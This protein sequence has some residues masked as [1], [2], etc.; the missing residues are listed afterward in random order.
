MASFTVFANPDSTSKKSIP[1]LLDIQSELLSTLDTRVVVPLYL[2]ST[3]Q[4]LPISRLTPVLSFQGK[5][6]VAMV[7]ELAGVSKRHLGP[8]V[9]TLIEARPELLAAL[10]LLISGF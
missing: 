9:G 7:P 1:F 8:P 2:K 4:I 3:A 5:T 10:D 6:L